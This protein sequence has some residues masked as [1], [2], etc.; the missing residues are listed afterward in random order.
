MAHDEDDMLSFYSEVIKV[1]SDTHKNDKVFLMSDFSARIETERDIW[2]SWKSP[3]LVV[4][5]PMLFI[6]FTYALS[7]TLSLE[8][9]SFNKK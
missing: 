5:T 3:G 4:Q 9:L 1:I 7:S 8:T 2:S 6:Y